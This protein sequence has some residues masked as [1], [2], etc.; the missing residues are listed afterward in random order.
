MNFNNDYFQNTSALTENVTLTNNEIFNTEYSL[1]PANYIENETI[2][3][4]NIGT[5]FGT[6]IN[7]NIHNIN[8]NNSDLFN[9][10]YNLNKI[11]T[12]LQNENNHMIQ[13]RYSAPFITTY[14][15]EFLP[16]VINPLKRKII[17]K[18]L[19]F[20]TKFRENYLTT[21]ASNCTFAMPNSINKVIQLE[22][23]SIELP[24]SYFNISSKYNNN[25]FTV[26]IDDLNTII[27]IPDG[28]YNDNTLI[29]AVNEELNAANDPFNNI[30][31]FIDPLTNRI[32]IDSSLNF[33]LDF[34]L[35]SYGIE[36]NTKLLLKLGWIL[37]FRGVIY[38]NHNNYTSEA[39]IDTT[40]S[41][42]FFLC[43][44][45]YNSSVN[46]NF[47]TAYPSLI[48]SKNILARVSC[49]VL[50]Q[51]NYNVV[52]VPREYFGPVSLQ[53]VNIQLLDDYGRI[54]DLNSDYSFC[55]TLTTSYDI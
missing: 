7:T 49:N 25:F 31:L 17:T 55:I 39:A 5:P 48:L 52:S 53:S 18:Q 45:D 28:N 13:N 32:N 35:N 1:Q 50:V 30:K 42:Y 8:T 41:K 16:G 33:T 24:K 44:N 3:G 47:Y 46:I 6:S 20:D 34:T 15:N 26:I 9:T 19:N 14:P 10:E 36:D 54:V 51:T 11:K 40:G 2:I 12:P 38:N 29:N 37:G 21:I 22:L 27:K 43:V 23:S 4:A